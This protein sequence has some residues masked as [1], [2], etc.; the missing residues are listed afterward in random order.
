MNI[1]FE[2]LIILLAVAVWCLA[3]FLFKPLGKY[4]FRIWKDT[5]ENM[6]IDEKDEEEKK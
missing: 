5:I 4:L 6:E 3:S 2:F 1:V